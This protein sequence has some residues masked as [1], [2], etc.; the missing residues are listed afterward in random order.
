[1]NP[2]SKALRC[3]FLCALLG[4]EVASQAGRKSAPVTSVGNAVLPL[5]RNGEEAPYAIVRLKS[6]RP[7]FEPKGFLKIAL[8]RKTVVEGLQIEVDRAEDALTA[9]NEFPSAIPNFPR[10][11]FS[12]KNFSISIRGE[13]RPVLQAEEAK[14]SRVPGFLN[15]LR[16][17]LAAAPQEV[18]ESAGLRL[19]G[20]DAGELVLASGRIFPFRTKIKP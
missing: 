18:I 8:L 4:L 14:A 5:F 3:L 20:P 16:V 17:R 15:F 13:S 7:D 19:S 1:M 11:G 10:D 6:M 12:L 2:P 9:L